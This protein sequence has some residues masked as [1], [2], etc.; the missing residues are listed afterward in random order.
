MA[1]KLHLTV[2]IDLLM[3]AKYAG[4]HANYMQIE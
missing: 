3:D 4:T 1:V 2:V